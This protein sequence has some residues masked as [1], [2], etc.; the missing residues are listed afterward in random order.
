M[1]ILSLIFFI[2][3]LIYGHLIHPHFNFL[4]KSVFFLSSTF[5][6]SQ[7]WCDD[8]KCRAVRDFLMSKEMKNKLDAFI[9][10]HT[11]AQL[12]IHPYSHETETY[13]M[14]YIELVIC[15]I[16]FFFLF[17]V[18]ATVVKIFFRAHFVQLKWLQQRF[19]LLNS[20]NGI[21]RRLMITCMKLDWL[22]RLFISLLS[23]KLTC[24]FR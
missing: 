14:D 8:L 13:P 2:L 12:W 6:H 24:L 16:L 10:L 17:A 18:N 7:T 1:E 21:L 23:L 11:Y 20:F 5:M 15:F 19:P 4:S 9:T 3:L 22:F